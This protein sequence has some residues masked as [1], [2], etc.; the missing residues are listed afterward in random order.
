MLSFSYLVENRGG[1]GIS[2]NLID[3]G[4]GAIGLL[5]SPGVSAGVA[6]AERV[7]RFFAPGLLPGGCNGIVAADEII[8]SKTQLQ[9]MTASGPHTERKF[10]PGTDSP[11]GCGSNSRYYV[12]WTVMQAPQ[13][14]VQPPRLLQ[15]Q[16]QG[17]LPFNPN[18]RDHR[19]TS[20]YTP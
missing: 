20:S 14:V 13:G 19:T 8:F 2:Q 9:Q 16:P 6:G 15:A 3:V 12:T 11:T 4:K 18:V 7:I 17:Q 10:Y 1:G 5:A